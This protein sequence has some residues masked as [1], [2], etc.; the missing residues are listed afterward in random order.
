[1]RTAFRNFIYSERGDTDIMAVLMILIIVI[2]LAFT[3]KWLSD[4]G[5]ENLRYCFKRFL[6][7][8]GFKF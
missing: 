8:L 6:K 3:F 1:M 4:N 2:S 5:W 7:R